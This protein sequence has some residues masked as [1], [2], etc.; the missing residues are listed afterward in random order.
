MSEYDDFLKS[1]KPIVL[2]EISDRETFVDDSNMLNTITSDT[3]IMLIPPL[4]TDIRFEKDLPE[5]HPEIEYSAI[6]RNHPHRE[7]HVEEA[8]EAFSWFETTG[9]DSAEMVEKKSLINPI[10]NQHLCGSCWAMSDCFVASGVVTWAPRIAPTCIMMAVPKNMGN[11]QCNGGNPATACRA[12]EKIPV[13]DTSCIDYSW[14]S[15]DSKMCTARSAVNHFG[16]ELGDKL[17]AKIPRATDGNMVGCYFKQDKMMYTLDQGSEAYYIHNENPVETFRKN[18]KTHLVDFGPVVAG[19]AVLKNFTTGNFSDLNINQGIY[20]DRADYGSMSRGKRLRFSDAFANASQLVGLHAVRVVGWGV[21]KNV[22]YDNN[23]FGD[24][25]YWIAANSWGT[26]WGNDGTF[27][28]AMYPFNKYAQFGK[29]INVKGSKI[30]GVILMRATTKPT[31]KTLDQ[32][33]KRYLNT[34]SRVQPDSYYMSSA[35]DA[36]T[37]SGVDDK[38]GGGLWIYI[39]IVLVILGILVVLVR[40]RRR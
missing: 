7:H 34:I 38:S 17:N 21:G 36:L 28:I 1:R 26:N 9:R 8:M 4:N 16:G 13:C 39:A 32:I 2:Q 37:S 35:D 30:G 11:G 14:C 15:S 25:P 19:Y 24:V 27:R 5:Y 12:I 6:M 23:M 40:Q 22:Q 3:D 31:S 10:Q 18:L 33:D 20:F 29:Q